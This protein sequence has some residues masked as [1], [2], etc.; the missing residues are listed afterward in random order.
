[1]NR[2][3]NNRSG[4]APRSPLV[5]STQRLSGEGEFSGGERGAQRPV[6]P[7]RPSSPR[8]PVVRHPSYPLPSGCSWNG[9]EGMEGMEGMSGSLTLHASP[10]MMP[11]PQLESLREILLSEYLAATSQSSQFTSISREA[12][13]RCVSRS[14]MK[15]FNS[16]PRVLFCSPPPGPGHRPASRTEFRCKLFDG[17]YGARAL[18]CPMKRVHSC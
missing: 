15:A 6:H 14:G 16:M 5:T 4:C 12:I 2:S 17:N 3:L 1:M 13:A 18:R 8:P 11:Q 9:M 7:A 10:Q